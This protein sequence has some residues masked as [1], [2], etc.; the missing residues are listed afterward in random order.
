MSMAWHDVVREE[1]DFSKVFFSSV[2]PFLHFAF[3]L[4]EGAAHSAVELIS[5]AERTFQFGA[6]CFLLSLF[7]T[8]D[9]ALLLPPLQ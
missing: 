7:V 9:Q 2:A 5:P 3:I 6:S 1:L 8:I 4:G